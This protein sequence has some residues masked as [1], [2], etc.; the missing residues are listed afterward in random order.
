[1]L[2]EHAGR[3]SQG[4]PETGQAMV[5]CTACWLFETVRTLVEHEVKALS[6]HSSG[7][8]A[9]SLVNGRRGHA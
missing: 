4:V 2:P 1:M 6:N 3:A 8:V 9:F 5:A 7:V